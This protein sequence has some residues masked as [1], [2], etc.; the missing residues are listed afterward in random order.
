MEPKSILTKE[1]EDNLV[2]YMMKMVRLGH[3]LSVNDL[4]INVA[5]ICK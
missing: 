3:L 1:E 4:K 2:T 5:E